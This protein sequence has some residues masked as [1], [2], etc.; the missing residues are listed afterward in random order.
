[1]NK[2]AIISTIVLF[3][4]AASAQKADKVMEKSVLEAMDARSQED[5]DKNMDDARE[6]FKK[7]L[8]KDES[9]TMAHF[10]LSVVYSYDKYTGKDYFEAWKHFQ[11][12]YE[13][14]SDYDEDELEV[15]NQYF[16]KEDLKRRNRPLNKNMDWEK[17][18]VE[19]KLIKFV[20]EENNVEY[21]ERF[22]KEFPNSK[23]VENVEH[24]R[25][26]IEFRRAENTNTVEAFNQFISE[27]P[28]AAQ[29]ELAIKYRDQ[30]AYDKAVAKN[31][32]SAL[33]A[34]VAQYPKAEQVEDAKKKMSV[35]AFTEAKNKH[36]LAAIEHFME[37]YPNSTKMPEAKILKRQLLFE[38]A[39]ELNTLEA[40]NKF[41]AQYPEG[42]LYVDIFNLK[43]GVLGER[44]LMDFPMENYKF[45]KGFDNQGFN[46]FGG[47]VAVRPNGNV[48]VLG[49]SKR[50]TGSMNDVWVIGL[51]T[52]GKML[53]N[54]LIGNEFDDQVNQVVVNGQNEI[55]AAGVT[56]AIKDSIKGK[57]WIFKLDADGKNL[58]NRTIDGYEINQLAVYPDEKALVS[59]RAFN[60]MD[61]TDYSFLAKVNEQGKKLWDRTYSQPGNIGGIALAPD[62]TAFVAGESWVF[63]VDENGYLKWDYLIEDEATKLNSVAL[64]KDGKLVFFGSK[65]MENMAMG[66]DLEGNKL[67]ETTFERVDLATPKEITVLDDNSIL[68]TS[69]TIDKKIVISKLSAGG[70]FESNKIFP[71]P[72]G[73]VLNGISPAGDN[74]AIV[75]AT[76]L[77]QQDLLV[78]K[79]GF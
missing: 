49:N 8:E 62:N 42:E 70:T 17:N 37:T 74:F 7:I 34:F 33:K 5:I 32:L 29:V 65:E 71:L 9:E 76:R 63:A 15:M 69:E 14:Q 53:W 61:S 57:A 50:D 20:R 26:Y 28:N 24:I 41:V 10:G 75:S 47:D 77:G 45:I 79:L 1:M 38:W 6:D 30:I 27:F 13:N 19:D 46:D 68:C 73:V 22:L 64:T 12:A 4:F 60:V 58:Y 66:F 39:K 44:L 36:T 72:N 23:Y 54:T 43:A 55:F 16:M 35:L 78:F 67:W 59:G 25:N 11:K 56:N 48:L 31:S 21:A 40:Y 18:I 51:N 2:I 3:T 52:E